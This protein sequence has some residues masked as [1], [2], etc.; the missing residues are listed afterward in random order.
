MNGI[1]KITA[2][3]QADAEEEIRQI[4]AQAQE[5][6]EAILKQ[7]EAQAAATAEEILRRGKKAAQERRER[8]ES[9]AHM[10]VRKLKLAAKQE[11]LEMAFD[12]ALQD[13]CAMPDQEYIDLLRELAVQVS[14]TGREQLVFSQKDRNRIGKQV[15][16]GANE[17]LVKERAPELPSTVADSKVGAFLGR[18]V[19]S[20]TA[21][22]TGTG[23][24]TLSEE[25]RP[26]QGGFIMVDGDVEMNCAFETLVRLQRDKLEQ[27]IAGILFA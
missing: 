18:V 24:L 10:E 25:T 8:L 21:M 15:V 4:Q 1:E 7:G 20:T 13:L 22:V 3:I 14:E 19:N 16:M 5:Q 23:L 9:A 2:R 17:L 12:Q 11:L 6:A 26:I 27:E